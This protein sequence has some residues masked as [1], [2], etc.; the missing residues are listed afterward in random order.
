MGQWPVGVRSETGLL[1]QKPGGS[2]RTAKL[3]INKAYLDDPI[4]WGGHS[5]P[6]LL[7]L[8]LVLLGGTK[9]QGQKQ[10]QEQSQRRRT[11]VSAPHRAH[12]NRPPAAM[13]RPS[14]ARRMEDWTSA[15]RW[16]TEA[17]SG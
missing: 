7:T 16:R 3:L 1:F 2:A 14:P 15:S 5:C 13:P 11:G 9:D 10:E 4:V 6:P 17:D 8:R 12:S